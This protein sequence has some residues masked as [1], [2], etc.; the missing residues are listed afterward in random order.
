[1][2]NQDL[3][4]VILFDRDNIRYFTGFRLNRAANSILVV[5][6]DGVPVYFVAQLDLERAKRSCWIDQVIAF[7]EDTSNYLSVLASLFQR[8]PRR[9]GVEKDALTLHQAELLRELANSG[10][11]L[12]DVRHLTAELR[13]IKSEEEI[14][15]IRRAAAIADQVMEE[16]LEEARPGVSEAELAAWGEY[17]MRLKGAEG[18][19]FEPFLMS[20]ENAWLPQRIAGERLLKAGELV[21]L[22]MGAIWD[23]YCSDLT[24]T[25]SLGEVSREQRRIFRV[26][27]EAQR[28]ALDAVRPGVT[29]F[30]VD[31]AARKVIEAGGLGDHFPHLTGHGV[32]VSVHE[33]PILDRGVDTI[34]RPG[35]VVTVE[36]GIYLPGVGAAR[37][38]DMVVVTSTGYELLTSARRDLV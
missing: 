2:R 6:R 12:V 34:L 38:E 5:G 11:K 22:D 16:I 30:E 32:G 19:S 21:L 18:P 33:P 8:G 20:G 9:I 13:V 25:F 29:A 15:C 3:D 10:M 23:G 17:R 35:M 24:R 14:G 28:A 7:P 36:P 37:I 4:L 31:R 26:A 1:M 27:W